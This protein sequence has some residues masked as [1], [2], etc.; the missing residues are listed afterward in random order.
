MH[1]ARGGFPA[2]LLKDGRVLVAGGFGASTYFLASAEIY[3]PATGI[4]NTTGSLHTGRQQHSAILLPNGKV[5]VTGGNTS[6]ECAEFCATTTAG[7]ELFNPATGTWSKVGSM[8][9]PRAF[10]TLTRLTDGKVLAA[11]G[12]IEVGNNVYS[13]IAYAD[14]YD[15]ASKKW[16][17][18]GAIGTSRSN[19]SATR[20]PDGRVLVAGGWTGGPGSLNSIDTAEVYDPVTG[21]WSATGSMSTIRERHVAF[22]LA[23]GQVLVAGGDNDSDCCFDALSS[24][25]LYDPGNCGKP[26]S[27]CRRQ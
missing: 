10:F 1:D 14:L 8:T 2:T 26:N 13:S 18:T 25:E 16:S 19:H 22:L 27:L 7:S 21:A 6:R 11:G 23:A 20:L 24:A 12:R 15:P 4:W 17:A 3:D 5:L 9:I